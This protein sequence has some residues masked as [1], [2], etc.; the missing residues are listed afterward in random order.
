M[1]GE[2]R[3]KLDFHFDGE[4]IPYYMFLAL[5]LLCMDGKQS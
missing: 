5:S 4:K 1:E 3:K 2:G